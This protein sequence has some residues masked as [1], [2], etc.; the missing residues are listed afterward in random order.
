MGWATLADALR[1]A[2]Y[3]VAEAW[4]L[5]NETK[6]RVAHHGDAAFASSIFLAVRRR[7]ALRAGSYENEVR[8]DLVKI[9]REGVGTLWKMG[10]SGA[11]LVIAAVGAGLCAFTR[12]SR[13][14]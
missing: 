13:L 9:V 10:I 4:P 6:A 12:F 2:G 5:T 7:E 1:R 8:P 14:E 3:E 11:D